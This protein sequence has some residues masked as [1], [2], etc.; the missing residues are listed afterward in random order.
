MTKSIYGVQDKHATFGADETK[1]AKYLGP[2][3][4]RGNRRTTTERRAEVRFELNSA[5]RRVKTG[6]REDDVSITFY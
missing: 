6:R 3:G 1:P 4:R 2:E 5:D